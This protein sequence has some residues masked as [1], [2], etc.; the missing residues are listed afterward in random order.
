[1][2]EDLDCLA[3]TISADIK[4]GYKVRGFIVKK[5]SDLEDENG[6]IDY[7]KIKTIADRNRAIANQEVTVIAPNKKPHRKSSEQ[8]IYAINT[9]TKQILKFPS[10]KTAAG[11]FALPKTSLDYF[12]Q[13]SRLAIN[14]YRLVSAASV[15]DKD[16][17]PIKEKLKSYMA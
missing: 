4:A 12:M 3:S 6:K 13:N 10:I 1:M 17:N 15:E 16:G 11:V 7:S 8:A 9:K 14:N 5:A 2:A